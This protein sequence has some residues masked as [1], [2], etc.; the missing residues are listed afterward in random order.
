MG[1]CNRKQELCKQDSI[2][3]IQYELLKSTDGYD[4]IPIVTLE[5]AV[6]PL[7]PFLPKIQTYVGIVKEKC[8]N[9]A[10]GLTSDESASI[11]LY[12]IGW[13]P[14][15]ECLYVVLNTT[16]QSMNRQNLKP[17]FLY[18]KLLFTAVIR[19]PSIHLSV[20]RISKLALIKQYQKDEI[21]IWWDFP[22]CT[23]S[24]EH[25][26]TEKSLDKIETKTIFTIECNTIKD[27]HKHTY[28][29][30][31]NSLLILPG[32]QFK[33]LE[34]LEQDDNLHLITLQEIQSSFLLQ[35][36]TSH[37]KSKNFLR[38]FLSCHKESKRFSTSPKTSISNSS[39]RNQSLEQLVF[40]SG[41]GWTVDLDEQNITDQDIKFIVKHAIIKN[42][43]K[44]IR[45]RDNNITSLGA[46]TLA[47]GLKNNMTLESL[48]LRNNFI[49]DLGVKSLA[50]AIINSNLKTL[51][52]ESNG[53][54]TEGAQYLAQMLKN[55]QTLTELYLSKNHL[56]DRGVELLANVLN[57]DK[58]NHHDR[59]NKEV[60]TSNPSIL[61]HLYLGHNDITDVGIKHLA[62][63]L[64]TN[65][66]LTWL[67]L[68]GNEIGNRGVELLANTLAYHNSSLE[69]L[70]LNSNNAI[71][72]PSV[73]A[74]VQMLKRNHSL[75]TIYI[76]NC[77]LSEIAKQT[78]QEMIKSKKDFDLEV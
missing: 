63:M 54:T 55:N 44:R 75:K 21:I 33:V 16:L 19:L 37:I 28:C 7:T 49:S 73:D 67:W 47:E 9:P 29:Q 2:H 59:D 34:C 5:Q 56:G 65:R 58:K 43:C 40:E 24:I 77:N 76:N 10:D 42:H 41:R 8:E 64:K 1:A 52:L 48:D 11:M 46:L 36:Q 4:K 39:Y 31:D 61:Q 62:D 45:L 6:L 70:F 27:I 14:M 32:T 17:W 74:L 69:W 71:S 53:I 12:S 51:N 35:A 50:L 60:D 38:K 18:L 30:S 26:Q 78:L 72:D 15:N 13:Q 23:T 22:L 57:D 68:S 25:F 66:M 20:Y 3:K